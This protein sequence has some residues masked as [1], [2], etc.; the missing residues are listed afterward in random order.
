MER[1]ACPAG[2]HFKNCFPSSILFICIGGKERQ[3]EHRQIWTNA[4][5]EERGKKT[6]LTD[7]RGAEERMGRNAPAVTNST[8]HSPQPMEEEEEGD[9]PNTL[10]HF[11]VPIMESGGME[12]EG[13]RMKDVQMGIRDGEMER[14]RRGRLYNRKG[15]KRRKGRGGDGHWPNWEIR[16]K[17]WKEDENGEAKVLEEWE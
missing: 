16:K 4:E 14:R 8:L 17:T 11:L 6:R 13:E 3:D 7:G 12:E 15:W 5:G 10:A 2:A 1:A 9:R